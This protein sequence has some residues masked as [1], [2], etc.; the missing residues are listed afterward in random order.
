VV[1]T[2]IADTGSYKIMLTVSD[3]LQSS[4][5][6]SFTLS[7][8]NA[9][10][11]VVTVPGDVS[12]VHK[13]NLTIP[14]A[15]SFDDDEG[16]AIT[17]EATYMVNGGSAVTIPNGIFS[18]PS[19]FTIAVISTSILDTGVYTI[20]LTVSDPLSASVTQTFKVAV[21]NTAP[22]V[23]SPPLPSYSLVHGKSI[24]MPLAGCFKDDEGD[25]M[26]MT[27][28]Y[29]LNG[30][31]AIPIQG[32]LFT[33]PTTFTIN[34]TSVGLSDVGIYTISVTISDS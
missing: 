30:G 18:V 3:E 23:L 27:A 32:G 8:T 20:K 34:A 33:L 5:T 28:T 17:M 15:S 24:S 13:S 11:K 22:R 6:T 31:A 7:V 4:M 2:S 16:D 29:S 14:L 10:P 9:A 26:T 25:T 1:S 12:L 19:S 21:T